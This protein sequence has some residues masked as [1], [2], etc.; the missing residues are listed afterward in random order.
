MMM[1]QGVLIRSIMQHPDQGHSTEPSPQPVEKMF[2]LTTYQ[3]IV[4]K[5][6]SYLEADGTVTLYDEEAGE[7][8]HH[9]CFLNNG[10]PLDKLRK[11]DEKAWHLRTLE[12]ARHL[13]RKY[14][15]HS[16]Y[17]SER[18]L[19]LSAMWLGSYHRQDEAFLPA[20]LSLFPE[21]GLSP[22]VPEALQRPKQT[23][24]P[25]STP[26]YHTGSR[27]NP[28]NSGQDLMQSKR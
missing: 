14:I 12:V 4:E 6:L 28:H 10:E 1:L 25:D 26:P 5:V 7:W 16:A 13:E 17:F 20:V 11:R 3:E 2:L 27:K 18:Y 15:Q 24:R 23:D 19:R 22:R 9:T 8:K 21:G